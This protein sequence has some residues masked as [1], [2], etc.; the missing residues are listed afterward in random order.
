MTSPTSL[1]DT[2]ALVTGRDESTL[3]AVADGLPDAEVHVADLADPIQIETLA[4]AAHVDVLVNDAGINHIGAA[5]A[6]D[7][8]AFKDLLTVNVLAPLLLGG[9]IGVAMAARGGG[10]IVNVSSGV[11]REG[12]AMVA[13]YGGTK[14]AHRRHHPLAGRRAR[15]RG[16]ARQRRAPRPDDDRHAGPADRD[17]RSRRPAGRAVADRPP[18]RAR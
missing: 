14:G 6:I 12:T 5:G 18:R 16:R 4:E 10:A 2:T 17:P 3:R 15:R 9:R 1:A 11:S 8:P 13:A 7:G